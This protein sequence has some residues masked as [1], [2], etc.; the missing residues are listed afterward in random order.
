MDNNK[1]WAILAY[2][3]NQQQ[4]HPQ[5]YIGW[6]RQAVKNVIFVR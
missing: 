2:Q 3:S 5:Q 4:K 6:S 1:T